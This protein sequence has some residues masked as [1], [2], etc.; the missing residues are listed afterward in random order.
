MTTIPTSDSNRFN[1]RS[2]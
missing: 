2:S 1:I